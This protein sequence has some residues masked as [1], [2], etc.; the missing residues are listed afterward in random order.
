MVDDKLDEEKV[1]HVAPTWQ[2][3]YWRRVQWMLQV[4]MDEWAL[5]KVGVA[6]ALTNKPEERQAQ[7]VWA[8]LE[9]LQAPWKMKSFVR[10]FGGNW[11]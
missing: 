6:M 4:T 10:H 11:R 2:G 8:R 9:K 3:L 1:R 5:K 7:E